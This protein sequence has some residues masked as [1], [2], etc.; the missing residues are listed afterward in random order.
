ML[1]KRRFSQMLLPSASSLIRQAA[2]IFLCTSRP[3][4]LRCTLLALLLYL[5]RIRLHLKILPNELSRRR[6]HF[7][8]PTASSSNLLNGL[9]YLHHCDVAGLLA[10]G[11]AIVPEIATIFM[12][13]CD[14]TPVMLTCLEHL[15]FG[16][17]SS[18]HHRHARTHTRDASVRIHLR[19][20][21]QDHRPFAR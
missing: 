12:L 15:F 13:R 21:K 10:S 16:C 3:Q 20:R 11:S 19:A 2:I 6:C 7:A 8:V 9:S 18:I 14:R 1:P 17:E 4:P 5:W